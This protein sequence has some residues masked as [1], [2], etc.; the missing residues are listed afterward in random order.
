MASH[1]L[2]PGSLWAL[3]LTSSDMLILR[4]G[5]AAQCHRPVPA[6][7]AQMYDIPISVM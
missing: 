1:C 7:S 6:I 4:A 3:P 5:R 2:L